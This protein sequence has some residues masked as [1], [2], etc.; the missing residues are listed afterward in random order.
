MIY[1]TPHPVYECNSRGW[2]FPCNCAYLK[3]FDIKLEQVL[4]KSLQN[5]P[6]LLKEATNKYQHL[7]QRMM[8]VGAPYCDDAESTARDSLIPLYHWLLPYKE[9][10]RANFRVVPVPDSDGNGGV[11]DSAVLDMLAGDNVAMKQDLLKMMIQS[12]QQDLTHLHASIQEEKWANVAKLA[13]R[14][15]GGAQIARADSLATACRALE[16]ACRGPL[17]VTQVRDKA[18]A[19]CTEISKLKSM[20][21]NELSKLGLLP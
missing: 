21:N 11:F 5:L 17:V 2:L 4:E 13:H 20:L 8:R 15:K 14:L 9:L 7:Y 12:N 19:V 18:E 6:S 10:Q 16:V 1:C 3:F